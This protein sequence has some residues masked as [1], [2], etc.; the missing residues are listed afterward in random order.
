MDQRWVEPMVMV[1]VKICLPFEASDNIW[2]QMSRLSLAGP[3]INTSAFIQLLFSCHYHPIC[4]W[5]QERKT[6]TVVI[7]NTVISHI[8]KDFMNDTRWC[9]R[10]ITAVISVMQEVIAP[11]DS[12]LLVHDDGQL[13]GQVSVVGF[14]F[15][16]IL[17]LVFFDQPLV[18][19]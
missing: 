9:V 15:I 13:S 7:K 11:F 2:E 19:A 4:S 14:H 3:T 8:I 17:L 1:R 10:W 16:M 12:Y 5:K 6:E 18:D